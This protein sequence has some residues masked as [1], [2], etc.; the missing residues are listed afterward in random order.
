MAISKPPVPVPGEGHRAAQ[1][2]GG[3][4]VHHGAR[5]GR[6][7]AGAPR[8]D[9]GTLASRRSPLPLASMGAP[10]APIDRQLRT[11]IPHIRPCVRQDKGADFYRSFSI[12]IA[13]LDNIKARIWLNSTLFALAEKDED[14]EFDLTYVCMCRSLAFGLPACLVLWCRALVLCISDIPASRLIAFTHPQPRTARWCPWWTAARRASRA[15]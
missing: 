11:Y 10:G 2:G 15:R 14:G 9:P 3:R 7:G 4:G 8:E 5:A 6:D 13:G 12:V 1:G